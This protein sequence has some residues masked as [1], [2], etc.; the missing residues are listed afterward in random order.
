[1]TQKKG[2][3]VVFDLTLLNKT[4]YNDMLLAQEYMV[5][6]KIIEES[7]TKTNNYG[8]KRQVWMKIS[9]QLSHPQGPLRHI[10]HHSE[11]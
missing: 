4:A 9:K 10:Q 7:M 6:F 8:D 1:M 3:K 5:C 2:G 11:A